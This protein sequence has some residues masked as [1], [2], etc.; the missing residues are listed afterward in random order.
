MKKK[1]GRGARFREGEAVRSLREADGGATGVIVRQT[2]RGKLWCYNV[3][4]DATCRVVT[5]RED[6]LAPH[7]TAGARLEALA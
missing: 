3:M 5:R 6:E 7:D 1:T 2:R 4:L